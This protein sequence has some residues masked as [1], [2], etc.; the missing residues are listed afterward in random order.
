MHHSSSTQMSLKMVQ[1]EKVLSEEEE[2]FV[3]FSFFKFPSQER[4][5]FVK[6]LPSSA[7]SAGA[8]R[9]EVE[10]FLNKCCM[11]V[12]VG[13]TKTVD[14]TLYLKYDVFALCGDAVT[15]LT[16]EASPSYGWWREVHKAC[17]GQVSNHET[18]IEL[19]IIRI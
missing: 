13:L 1:A 19:N 4:C 9:A 14:G 8:A 15:T 18:M 7:D 3:H 6:S 11:G 5:V 2:G 17:D 10:A 16:S 12:P